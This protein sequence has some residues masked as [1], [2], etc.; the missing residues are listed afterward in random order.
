MFPEQGYD[1]PSSTSDECDISPISNIIDVLALAD[2]NRILYRCENEERDDGMGGGVYNI[3]GYGDLVY[4]GL[5]GKGESPF[6]RIIL[7]YP[8]RGW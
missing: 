4:C 7:T 5:Q 6:V 1:F 2:L 8:I 3:P